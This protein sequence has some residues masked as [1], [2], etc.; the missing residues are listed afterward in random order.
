MGDMEDMEYMQDDEDYNIGLSLTILACSVNQQRKEIASLKTA[1]AAAEDKLTVAEDEHA[2]ALAA[3]K[4]KLTVAEDEHAAAL[5]AAEEKH[6]ATLTAALA[7]ARATAEEKQTTALAAAAALA[8]ADLAAALATAT[9]QRH[10]AALA[11]AEAHCASEL[12]KQKLQAKIVNIR[13]M[14]KTTIAIGSRNNAN[15]LEILNLN[16]E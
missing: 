16:D 3:A 2:A 9:E 10:A 14:Q 15:L 1:L 8:A 11:A 7:A 13:L 4:E 5:A 6:T 12:E